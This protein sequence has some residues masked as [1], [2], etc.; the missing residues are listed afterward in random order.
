MLPGAVCLLFPLL[1]VA[2]ESLNNQELRT[3]AHGKINQIA[4][5]LAKIEP[6]SMLPMA[7]SSLA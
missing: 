5:S 4:P 2:T 3:W 7:L 1:I 6:K